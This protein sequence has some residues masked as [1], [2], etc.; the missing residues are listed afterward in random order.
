MWVSILPFSSDFVQ[1]IHGEQMTANHLL[2]CAKLNLR[3][4]QYQPE[5]EGDVG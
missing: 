1:F 4:K 3:K 2:S 5:G